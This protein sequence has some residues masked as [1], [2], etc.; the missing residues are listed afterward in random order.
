MENMWE[1]HKEQQAQLKELKVKLEYEKKDYKK[2]LEER[3]KVY[4]ELEEIKLKARAIVKMKEKI[5]ILKGKLK[6]TYQMS[7]QRD[8]LISK[9]GRLISSI[10]GLQTKIKTWR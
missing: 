9:K 8:G 6:D 2:D 4:M 5:L 7:K 1:S 3:S 10:K